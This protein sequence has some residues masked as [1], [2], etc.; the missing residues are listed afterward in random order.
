MPDQ[1]ARG[2]RFG[3]E[4][5]RYATGITLFGL[6]G[7]PPFVPAEP[8]DPAL[9]GP[10]SPHRLQGPGTVARICIL[11]IPPI[12]LLTIGE[13]PGRAAQGTIGAGSIEGG[14]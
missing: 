13:K 6:L 14:E 2:V 12:S 1:A 5:I 4:T 3:E 8:F 7:R 9:T 11:P 10:D